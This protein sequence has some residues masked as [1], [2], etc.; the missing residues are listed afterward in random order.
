[1]PKFNES[2]AVLF[3]ACV[4][5][6]IT[7]P[8][9]LAN[10]MGNAS[11]E[12]R[13][14]TTM[15]EF[16]GYTTVDNVEKAVSSSTRRNTREQVQQAI[17]S[18]DPEQMAHILYDGRRDL[19]NTEPGDG[20]KYH[21]RGYFQYTGKY[22]YRTFGEKYGYD[23]EHNPDL[24]A[25]PEF[26]AKL[27]VAYWRD[28]VPEIARTDA[29]AAGVAINGGN[30]GSTDRE[31]R[32]VEWAAMITPELVRQV[33][34]GALTLEQLAQ[35]G[36]EDRH[37]GSGLRLRDSGDDV[38]AMQGQL[39]SLGYTDLRGQPIQADGSF[40]PA[41]QAAVRAFQREYDLAVDGI[42]GPATLRVLN[43]RTR[44]QEQTGQQ[45]PSHG[46]LDDP[47]H[48]GHA[49]F[50]QARG[51]VYRLDQQ[52]GHTSDQRSDNLAAALTVSALAAGLQRID[53]IALSDDGNVLWAVQR[54]EGVHDNFFDKLAN[55][56]IVQGLNTPIEQS[57]A[58]WPQAVQQHQQHVEGQAQQQNQIE[59][60]VQHPSDQGPRMVR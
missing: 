31:K 41:T 30:N 5:A 29:R 23:L 52:V 1:M 18:R 28:V 42:A 15:H 49:F 21:G 22:N 9:E 46:R 16:F 56:P 20:W 11:V 25:E 38:R 37:H 27:A 10:I 3:K 24:A 2:S 12:T 13:N 53:R 58:Q 19:S 50:Q 14:Y 34:N 59:T 48:P 35:L 57:S 17:D 47:A 44:L 33:Q 40:G 8:A 60:Q 26:A 36:T 4:D 55:M 6:G 51:H 32:S 45:A 43:E 7:S 54:P 39:A